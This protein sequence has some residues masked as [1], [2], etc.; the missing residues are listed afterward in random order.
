MT[1]GE[2]QAQLRGVGE[3]STNVLDQIE[4]GLNVAPEGED[5]RLQASGEIQFIVSQSKKA[6]NGLFKE[7]KYKG[8]SSSSSS[9][10]LVNAGL[11]VWLAEL[12]P[13]FSSS[14]RGFV[15]PSLS[16]EPICPLA[17][18]A[19]AI[20]MYS[21]AIAGDET[22]H[23]LYSNRAAA[24]LAVGLL[25]AALVDAQKAVSLNPEWPK[26]YYRLGCALESMN[27]MESALAAFQKGSRLAAASGPGTPDP[28]LEAKV[29]QSR[30]QVDQDR[31][32]MNAAAAVERHNL[33]AKLRNARHEDQK[34][35]M[36]N[37]F[38]QSMTAPDWELE[39]LE[40]RPT[41]THDLRTLPIVAREWIATE[42]KRAGLLSYVSAVGDIGAPKQALKILE[43]ERR[44]EWFLEACK[45]ALD[46]KSA[47]VVSAGGGVLGLIAAK[48][49][50]SWVTQVERSRMLYRMA[51]Q[52]KESNERDEGRLKPLCARIDL[53]SGVLDSVGVSSTAEGDND[54][55]AGV[56]TGAISEKTTNGPPPELLS[57]HMMK[58]KA[59]ALVIDL[60]DHTAL[61]MG[62]LRA[63]D[64]AAEHLLVPD[65]RVV[66]G[67]VK[68]IAQLVQMK[69][70]PLVSG[71]DLSA[72]DQYRWHP[73]DERVDLDATSTNY[74]TLSDPFVVVD[75]DLNARVRK[76]QQRT[77]P[78]TP[79][80][81]DEEAIG[82]QADQIWELDD[83]MCVRT[84][85]SG[86]WNA[87][88]FWFEL[89][90]S[91]HPSGAVLSS[92][93]DTMESS[94]TISSL[95]WGQAIQYVGDR[96]LDVGEDVSLRVQQD[97]SQIVFMADPPNHRMHH[98][99]VP[100][101][102]YDMIL[103]VERNQAYDKA[104][105]KAVEAKKAAY[106]DRPIHC[107][108]MGAGS[109]L[110]SMMAARAGADYTYAAEMNSHMCDVAEECTISNGFLD[111][112]LVL[113]RD[114]R[115]MDVLR[116]P[117]GTAP[118]LQRPVDLAVFEV[119]DSGL[120]GEGVLH[121]LAA[122]KSKLL[123]P[124]A[125]LVP[126]RAEVFAQ[127]IQMRVNTVLGDID[128]QQT[129][130][131]RW[132]A[133]YEGV[134][135]GR[136]K[137]MHAW[138]PLAD[139]AKV[140]SFDFA[141]VQKC[142]EDSRNL[143]TFE[144]TADGTC[145]AIAMWF[146]LYLD[147][148]DTI[149]LSTSP[150][151]DKGPTWQQAVQYIQEVNLRKGDQLQVQASHDTYSI[152]YELADSEDMKQLHSPV[153]KFDGVWKAACDRLEAFNS[154]LV[155]SCVQSPLEYRFVSQSAIQL[156]ARAADFRLEASQASEFASRMMG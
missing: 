149:L 50:A 100:R 76:V 115:R 60:L 77:H 97:A 114:V 17:S 26:G 23:T 11:A 127:P 36:L 31:E 62:L 63:V 98:A 72:M 124:D 103:D 19:D 93:M 135:L 48:V 148:E 64:H 101:W 38:K 46:A 136:K 121:V 156:A 73:G 30:L 155:K 153:P 28:G 16:Y 84:T 6:G 57:K 44:L 130:R 33:V 91:F 10:S 29:R 119:F 107:I 53:V 126:C 118:E 68:I 13:F 111:R 40:W 42:P 123:M 35:S 117:D 14:P 138:M 137:N 142:A 34:L 83:I 80:G 96:S 75:I 134:E 81:T 92:H 106:P 88:V 147:E 61:G 55:D 74:A 65:A 51:K 120:I 27:E 154:E 56:T 58:S 41:W 104:I 152:S 108:D 125:S 49:G 15:V 105:K 54:G 7:K 116:K 132:R 86:H 109:G 146:N 144:S 143:L 71:F 43:D 3:P 67:N 82:E 90:S 32:A 110:L 47:L 39:D 139:P 70:D 150:Y 21:Q 25:D 141:D 20:K 133:D 87:I 140:F 2:V 79:E 78:G 112:I 113:D 85:A 12:D 69:L 45:G 94:T 102:H 4:R 89:S 59:D 66:P 1:S 128:V 122:A 131:W 8:Q 99:L 129:N 24:Y 37:Q 9:Q 95:S 145:N 151:E 22:D 18:T 5:T 52:V